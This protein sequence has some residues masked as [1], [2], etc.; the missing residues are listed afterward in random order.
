GWYLM[1]RIQLRLGLHKDGNVAFER[2]REAAAMAMKLWPALHG[3]PVVVDALIDEAGLEADAKAWREIR[4]TLDPVMALEQLV[5]GHSPVA[6]KIRASKVWSE[7]PAHVRVAEPPTLGD[8]RLA[9]LLGDPALEARARAA[10]DDKLVGMD[11]A[12][13]L[14]LDPGDPRLKQ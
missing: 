12:L 8:V 1:S 10:F 5:T 4:R 9:R 11:L 13:A 2:G 6:T 3:E 14:V 7:V